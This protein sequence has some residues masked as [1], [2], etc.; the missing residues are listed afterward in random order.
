MTIPPPDRP[1]NDVVLALRVAR[2][3]IGRGS[4]LPELV[5]AVER[6]LG[7]LETHV[8]LTLSTSHLPSEPFLRD[9]NGWEGVHAIQHDNGV[10]MWVPDDPQDSADALTGACIGDP[11]D[12]VDDHAFHDHEPSVPPLILDIQSFARTIAGADWVNFDSDGPEIL[13]LPTWKW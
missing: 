8:M 13:D 7:Y 1:R 10:F 6:E 11:H 3:T 12:D 4:H 9:L 5:D 2:T